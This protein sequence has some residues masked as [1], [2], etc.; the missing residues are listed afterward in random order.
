MGGKFVQVINRE[1]K[2]RQLQRFGKRF[3]DPKYNKDMLISDH[4]IIIG[5]SNEK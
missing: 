3:F 1:T 2:D 4:M 5:L